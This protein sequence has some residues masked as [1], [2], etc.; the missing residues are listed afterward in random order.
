MQS[1]VVAHVVLHA[2]GPHRYGAQLVAICRHVPLPSQL[3][4]GIA[5][6]PVQDTVPQLV[7]AGIGRHAPLPSQVPL[8][9][10]GGLAAH[11]PCGSIA[12]AGTGRQVPALPAT[13][14]D[15]QVPQLVVEQ[16][17][18]STQL[19]L[20]HSVPAAQICPSRFLPHEPLLHTVPGTQSLS[21]AQAE[22]QV[23]PLQL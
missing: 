18:P 14:H 7:P 21:M 20:S 10:Q 3:P 2:V 1:A 23:V 9:P 4:T 8:N 11:P 12:P 22:R 16:H 6:D 19:P 15:V 5:V 17:T 13:L